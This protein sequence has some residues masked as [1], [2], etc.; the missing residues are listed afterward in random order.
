MLMCKRQ[1]GLGDFLIYI[2]FNPLHSLLRLWR[3]YISNRFLFSVIFSR[4]GAI[5][6]LTG[7]KYE[8]TVQISSLNVLSE[9]QQTKN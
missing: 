6:F 9:A 4:S 3:L 7:Q 8:V 2:F 1:A 5:I